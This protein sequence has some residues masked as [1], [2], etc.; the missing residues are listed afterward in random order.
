MFRIVS[1]ELCIAVGLLIVVYLVDMCSLAA[2]SQTVLSECHCLQG[3]FEKQQR[4]VVPSRLPEEDFSSDCS[5]SFAPG[6]AA[7]LVE[8]RLLAR[9]SCVLNAK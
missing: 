1:V 5:L 2:A 6:H 7:E 8:V 4:S 9:S 3:I